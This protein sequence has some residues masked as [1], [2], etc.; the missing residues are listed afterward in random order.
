M[1]KPSLLLQA[2]KFISIFTNNHP[3]FLPFVKNVKENA[4]VE[5]ATFEISVKKSGEE[6]LFTKIVLTKQ[7]A[8]MLAQ[9]L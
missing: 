5:G 7:E 4:L 3:E 1:I 6:P 2:K 9:I 8:Q